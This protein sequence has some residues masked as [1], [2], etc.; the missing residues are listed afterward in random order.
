MRKWVSLSAGIMLQMVLGSVYAWSVFTGPLRD[1]YGVTGG[2]S[3]FIFGLMIA[4]FSAATIPAG[5]LLQRAGPRF[6]AGTGAV[7]F[8]AGYILAYFSGGS[9]RLML[10]GIGIIAGIGI[11]FGY[12]CP[13]SVGMKWFPDKKGLITGIAVAGF[14]GGAIVMSSLA[15]RLLFGRGMDVL[16]VF[17]F[18]GVVYGG[19]AFIAAMLMREP[20]REEGP[21]PAAG[22]VRAHI[23]S[24]RFLLI[25]LGMFAGTF[26][27]LL[28]IGNLKPMMLSAGLGERWAAMSISLFA[29]GNVAGRVLWGRVHD[30]LE[31]SSTILLS[32]GVLAAGLLFLLLEL[33]VFWMLLVVLFVGAGFGGCFVVYA[34]SIAE[35]FGM[36]L[37]PKLYP[38][39][40]M[41]Y[42]LAALTGPP[43]GGWV[44]GGA[45]G[46]NA[47]IVASALV[48]LVALVVMELAN[49]RKVISA[50]PCG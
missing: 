39:C 1:V 33:P 41:F 20:V 24:L 17:G 38:V 50:D 15:E 26:A 8:G 28:V 4:V 16:G 30:R 43:L 9:Y 10:L 47:G 5:R 12:V 40:F 23:A 6:T 29:V 19:A 2:Q 36:C 46:Y 25:C 18:V 44:S 31:S 3:G 21:P 7:L 32:L 35:I 13:L 42:G 11:G 48:I 22:G 14:G 34:S 49:C 27:G 45:G 37:F